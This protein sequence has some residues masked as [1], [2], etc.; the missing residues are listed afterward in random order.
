M[1]SGFRSFHPVVAGLLKC[2]SDLYLDVDKG[3]YTVMIFV[4]LKKASDT[5]DH[6]ILLKNL[7]TYGVIGS[8]SAWFAF[9]LCNR[10]RHCKVNEVSSGLHDVNC[11]VPQGSCLGPVL[12]LIYVNDL[13]NTLQSSQVTMYADYTTFS[14]SSKN[15]VDLSENLNRVL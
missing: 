3:Q 12:I 9:Y 2:T 11:G 6:E 8:E 5:I 15:I 13:P 10:M 7:E 1:E 14:R 4:D